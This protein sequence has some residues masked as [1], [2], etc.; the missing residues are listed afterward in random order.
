MCRAGKFVHFLMNN[1]LYLGRSRKNSKGFFILLS[2]ANWIAGFRKR[3]KK[4]KEFEFLPKIHTLQ[5]ID[6]ML[7]GLSFG[8]YHRSLFFGYL[9]VV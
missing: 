1:I 7:R 5:E 8:G 2:R 4:K 6:S 9:F 3:K